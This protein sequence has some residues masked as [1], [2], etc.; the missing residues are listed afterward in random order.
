MP[1]WRLT[2][3]Y[4]GRDYVG[5][6]IQPNGLSVQEVLEKAL[7]RVL[8][9]PVRAE[10]AGR[11]DAG[12]HALGQV[13]A[14][15]TRAERDERALRDGVNANLPP[16]VA[17]VDA[18][19][20]ADSFNPRRQAKRKLYRYMWWDRRA[21]S[22]LRRGRVWYVRKRL[23]VSA[24]HEAG[25]FLVGQHDFASFRA[26]G[27]ASTHATRRI[28]QLTVSRHGDAVQLDVVGPAFLR[29]QIRIIAGTLCDVGMGR[30][31][32]AWVNDVLLARDRIQ[33]GRT[34]PAQGLTL[35]WIEYDGG[36]SR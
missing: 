27:C 33:A 13:V 1:R 12:V 14:V 2:V 22:P 24:M 4:D 10:A 11:T 32:P 23:D 26:N 19:L 15:T 30:R 6:A 3:E 36:R 29:H 31:E 21:R 16:S 28:D 18:V 25:Q 34:A 5:W 35:M 8:C 9:E 20:V 17:V 7:E